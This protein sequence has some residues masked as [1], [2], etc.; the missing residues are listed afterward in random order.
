MLKKLV[1][2]FMKLYDKGLSIARSL[3]PVPTHD[4]KDAQENYWIT[5]M[6]LSRS[7]F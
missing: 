6:I 1:D 4:A 5:L 3:S 7:H 2:Y